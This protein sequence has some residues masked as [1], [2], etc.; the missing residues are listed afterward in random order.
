M[1][2][3]DG[4]SYEGYFEH[5][6]ATGDGRLIKANGDVIDGQFIDGKAHGHGKFTA[7][8]G[9]TVYEGL[10]ENHL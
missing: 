9:S 1:F 4:S 5:N 10:W 7:Y 6:K 2:F 3:K 8:D